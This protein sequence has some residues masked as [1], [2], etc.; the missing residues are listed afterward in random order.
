MKN[1]SE[2]MSAKKYRKLLREIENFEE[3][4]EANLICT[5]RIPEPREL[6]RYARPTP[7]QILEIK[8]EKAI[9]DNLIEKHYV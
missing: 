1:V 4:Y 7:A 5:A 2:A 6:A 3:A 9:M 8:R